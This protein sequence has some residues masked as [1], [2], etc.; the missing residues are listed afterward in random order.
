VDVAAKVQANERDK[1]KL[2][3][4]GNFKLYPNVKLKRIF[5]L[6]VTIQVF[7]PASF[8]NSLGWLTF[9]AKN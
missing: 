8:I 1:L 7:N 2:L 3:V 9:V 5:H 4:E 6:L